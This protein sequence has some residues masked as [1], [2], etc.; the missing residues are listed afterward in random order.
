MVCGAMSVSR[1]SPLPWWG[2]G[3][4][5]RAGALP[6]NVVI[7]KQRAAASENKIVSRRKDMPAIQIKKAPAGV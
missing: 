6:R 5:S 4:I 2:E 1:P 3:R 7:A